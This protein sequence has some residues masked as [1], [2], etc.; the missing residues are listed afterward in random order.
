VTVVGET[1]LGAA[2]AELALASRALA[3]MAAAEMLT[4]EFGGLPVSPAFLRARPHVDL[5]APLVEAAVLRRFGISDSEPCQ[6]L[7]ATYD[8]ALGS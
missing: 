8:P 7:E 6:A 3:K 1:C 4:V 5:S 2:N